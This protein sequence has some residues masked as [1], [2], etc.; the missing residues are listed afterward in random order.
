MC[1]TFTLSTQKCKSKLGQTVIAAWIYTHSYQLQLRKDGRSTPQLMQQQAIIC[2]YTNSNDSRWQH[3]TQW[4]G[5]R[6]K[7]TNWL[8]V[9]NDLQIQ[10]SLIGQIQKHMEGGDWEQE[11]VSTSNSAS[12]AVNE[13]QCEPGAARQPD[14]ELPDRQWTLLFQKT[15]DFQSFLMRLPSFYFCN[16]FFDLPNFNLSKPR[17]EVKNHNFKTFVP[18]KPNISAT[19]LQPILKPL[20]KV[21]NTKILNTRVGHS[22]A[23]EEI[24][25][26]MY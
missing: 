26:T 12:R 8:P 23:P 10:P 9:W 15:L 4:V 1:K 7:D 6:G 21:L 3:K 24:C 19:Q 18:T 5:E 16:I 22:I 2:F 14:C 20:T 17:F 11:R 13:I 25:N